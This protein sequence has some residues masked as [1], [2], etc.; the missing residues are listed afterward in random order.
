MAF[1]RN[2]IFATFAILVAATTLFF[3]A[4]DATGL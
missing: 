2:I 4:P 3:I 1:N